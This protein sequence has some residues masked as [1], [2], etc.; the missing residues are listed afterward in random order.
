MLL[1]LVRLFLALLVVPVGVAACGSDDTNAPNAAVATTGLLTVSPQNSEYLIGINRVSLA[2]FDHIRH[3]VSGARAS[4]D[5]HGSVSGGVTLETRPLEDIGPQYGGIPIYVTTAK[6]PEVGSYKFVVRA[7]L[8]DGSS[9]SGEAIVNV[10]NKSREFPVGYTVPPLRQPITGDPGVTIEKIDSGVPPDSWHTAT[11]ADGLAQHR[12]MVLYFGEPG[13]C[14]SRTCGPTVK[15]LQQFQQQ[16]GASFLF[17]HIED[18]FPAGPDQTSTTN[19]AF[20]AF[21]LQTEPWVFFVNSSGVISDRFEGPI[22]VAELVSAAQ[23]TLAGK[24][25]AVDVSLGG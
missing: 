18:H 23:G 7:A 1:C 22:T 14:Q 2:L 21:G 8:A 16:A 10:T 17:E 6:F 20:A 3:P 13:F 11:I 5:V 25:P 15:V 4:L 19:P 24:V 12:P 9:I